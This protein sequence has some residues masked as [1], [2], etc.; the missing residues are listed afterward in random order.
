VPGGTTFAGYAE[1]LRRLL[2]HLG[3]PVVTLGGASAGGG[4]AVAAAVAHPR[5]VARLLL[6]SAAV[7]A[8]RPALR[9]MAPQVR[10]VLV[11]AEHAPRLAGRLLAAS[12]QV[13]QDS[14]A[15]RWARRRMPAGD[16]RVLDDPAWRA[17]LTEDFTEA[18]RQG[19]AA[20]VEDLRAYRLDPAGADVRRLT[21]DTVLLHGTDDV[22]AP[23]GLARWVASRVPGSRLVEL[24]GAGH[25]SA[26]EEPGLLL[27]ETTAP[28]R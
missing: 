19:P 5:R 12:V 2:D 3:L 18:L 13:G 9:G 25:L 20:A 26:L 15:A 24:P 21:V 10:A 27:R 11:L 16:R 6:V 28:L 17:R 7:P 1:D 22:N 4:F 14:A 8:P 23:I